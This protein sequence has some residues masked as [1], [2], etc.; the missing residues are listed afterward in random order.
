MAEALTTPVTSESPRAL[1]A[2][3]GVWEESNCYLDVL[4]ELL[5]ALGHQPE[6]ALAVTLS[7]DW[8]GDQWTFCKFNDEDLRCLYG[9][10]IQEL[11]PWHDLHGH[12]AQQVSAGKPVLIEV[13]SWF[14][15]D[16]RGSAYRQAHVKTTI[17][18][19]SME[20][21]KRH[22]RYLHG[23]GEWTVDGEDYDGL[24]NLSANSQ[25][26]LLPPYVERVRIGAPVSPDEQVQQAL[27][28]LKREVERMPRL[29][30]VTAFGLYASDQRATNSAEAALQRMHRFAFAT[31]RQIGSGAE[32]ASHG[33]RWI[34]ER[35]GLSLND[36]G[37]SC[38]ALARL[39][40]AEQF[41]FARCISRSQPFV[42][43]PTMG[44]LWD[45]VAERLRT[46]LRA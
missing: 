40:R 17:A 1:H 30:P 26:P 35:A 33:I 45:T 6:P 9:I 46:G 22:M 21:A 27:Y 19:M 13:D 42:L 43:S 24:W 3:K 12:V 2:G 7:A 36:V 28:I 39:A 37:D 10:D 31:F 29:N 15:P 16:T 44:E 5:H 11:N 23:T 34:E 25:A 41:R 18:V 4:I 14:L 20:P 8:E 32:L 38:M